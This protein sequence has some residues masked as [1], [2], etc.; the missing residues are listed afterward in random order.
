MTY[1]GCVGLVGWVVCKM[2]QI[3]A[4]WGDDNNFTSVVHHRTQS[5]KNVFGVVKVR[6]GV[7]EIYLV[8]KE[9][10]GSPVPIRRTVNVSEAVVPVHIEPLVSEVFNRVPGA[11]S[12]IKDATN[13]KPTDKLGKFVSIARRLVPP[14]KARLVCFEKSVV[15]QLSLGRFA[16]IAYQ[17]RPLSALP[18]TTQPPPDLL[19]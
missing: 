12:V 9:R 15:V 2:I 3:Y 5:V 16:P 10:E 7:H 11:A 13:T 4:I 19:N 17:L 1:D 6:E 18:D 14:F 8:E